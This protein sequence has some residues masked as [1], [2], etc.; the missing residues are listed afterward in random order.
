MLTRQNNKKS[1]N[2]KIHAP[3][4]EGIKQ[5][6]V[7]AYFAGLSIYQQNRIAF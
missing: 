2:I 7:D 3:K 5:K 4:T 6:V 1:I